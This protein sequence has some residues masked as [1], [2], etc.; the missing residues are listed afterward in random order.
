MCQNYSVRQIH[1]GVWQLAGSP[2]P[3]LILLYESTAYLFFTPAS[4]AP[5]S[6]RALNFCCIARF[7]TA[8]QMGSSAYKS[9]TKQVQLVYNTDC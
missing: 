8:C 3:Q 6:S 7:S 2:G 1:V 9:S 5:Q 4:R